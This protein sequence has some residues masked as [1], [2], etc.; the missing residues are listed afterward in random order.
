MERRL[1]TILCADVAGY[2]R[3]IGLEYRSK[4]RHVLGSQIF[5]FRLLY[6]G[7]LLSDDAGQG[8]KP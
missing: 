3:M 1:V 8:L 2:S 6:E 4:S 5:T 7:R